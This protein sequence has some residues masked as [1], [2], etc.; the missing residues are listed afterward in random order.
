MN[1]VK[2]QNGF[3]L[4]ELLLA[5]SF[6][7]LLLVAIAMTVIQIGNIYTRGMTLKDVN[8][9]G[10]VVV[11]DL[12]RTI[13]GASPFGL[14]QEDGRYVS[15]GY[16]GRL[17]TGRYT[18][19]W[20]YGEAIEDGDTS[21]LHVYSNSDET[22][23]LTKA[24]DPAAAYC[25]NPDLD[26]DYDESTELLK[27]GQRSLALHKFD[28][29]TEDSAR[30]SLTSQQLYYIEFIL[31]TNNQG[32]LEHNSTNTTCQP[33]SELESD[34]N[35]CAVNKFTIVVRAGNMLE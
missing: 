11:D 33:P 22:I 6:L 19:V 3:T 35:Y 9:A 8:Q 16:G 14:E 30:D 32:A 15:T 29:S 2:K 20:N 10:R 28:V 25:I 17:C 18:Y 23:R 13:G 27:D 34:I 5:M 24:F 1:H 4:V 31:G 7:S 26:I 12:Q 21:N